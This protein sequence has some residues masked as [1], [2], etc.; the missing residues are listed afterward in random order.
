MIR[1]IRMIRMKKKKKKSKEFYIYNIQYFGQ[2]LYIGQT[3]NIKRRQSQHN[4]AL[5]NP[6][7]KQEIYEYLRELG[8][9]EI[10]LTLLET[11]SDRVTAK[12]RECYL[13]LKDYFGQ[14]QL[15]NKIPNIS[16]R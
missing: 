5:K 12:R 11:Y 6:D 7:K 10:T 16:D 1:M 4:R 9:K 13:I 15:K 2:V 14:K 8:A 3:N